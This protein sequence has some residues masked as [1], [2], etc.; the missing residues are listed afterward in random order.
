MF[1]PSCN[2][3]ERCCS[4]R[5]RESRRPFTTADPS[6]LIDSILHETPSAP[7]QL[8]ANLS[9]LFEALLLKALQKGPADRHQSA[10]E[11]RGEFERVKALQQERSPGQSL[12][13]SQTPVLEMSYVLFTD[14]VGYSRLATDTQQSLLRQ[15]QRIVRGTQE[16]QSAQKGNRLIRL[17]NRRWNGAGVFCG[18]SGS[19][20][21]RPFGHRFSRIE[22]QVAAQ[23]GITWQ[24]NLRLQKSRFSTGSFLLVPWLGSRE[25]TDTTQRGKSR[26]PRW[27]KKLWSVQNTNA[28][29]SDSSRTRRK[30]KETRRKSGVS[31]VLVLTKI[32]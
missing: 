26:E 10:V 8:N 18:D 14:I 12:D 3:Q 24:D 29:Y 31:T 23:A 7:R 22:C 32:F 16:F 28:I 21:P 4:K 9:P 2:R 27:P 17:P 6:E 25:L 11:L 15:L 20:E 13:Q 5:R 1:E 30:P 19:C